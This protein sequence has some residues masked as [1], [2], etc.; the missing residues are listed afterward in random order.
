MPVL[1]KSTGNMRS[2]A[3]FFTGC[4]GSPSTPLLLVQLVAVDGA[5]G[6]RGEGRQVDHEVAIVRG[7]TAPRR[8]VR[9][10]GRH[11]HASGTGRGG[12]AARATY[13]GPETDAPPCIHGDR[14]R[15]VIHI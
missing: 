1:A 11:A 10:E 9:G 15:A 2:K 14:R 6:P 7:V 12:G 3:C 4:I 5:G 8:G 13:G